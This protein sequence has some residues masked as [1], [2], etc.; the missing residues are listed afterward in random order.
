[1]KW[2]ISWWLVVVPWIPDQNHQSPTINQP[3]CRQAGNQTH[4]YAAIRFSRVALVF[5][6]EPDPSLEA[7]F[8]QSFTN[9]AI[10]RR[11]DLYLLGTG[12]SLNIKLREGRVEVKQQQSVES[13][14]RVNAW[15]RGCRECWVKWSFDLQA[16]DLAIPLAGKHPE[17]WLPVRK[18]RLLRTFIPELDEITETQAG[19]FPSRGCNA[20][21]TF[22]EVKGTPWYSV[23][24]EAFGPQADRPGLLHSVA[25]YL[26]DRDLPVILTEASSF[27][28]AEWID[29]L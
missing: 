2:L 6:G 23:A 25:D 15:V 10:G 9:V 8:R 27:G 20:E 4:H 13:P 24:L 14:F 22:L 26:L 21:L 3:D 5:S 18:K 11:T 19:S 29:K 1:M 28:Y 7:W 16:G 17:A 12:K